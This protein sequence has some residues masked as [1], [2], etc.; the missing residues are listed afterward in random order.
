MDTKEVVEYFAK[1]CMKNCTIIIIVATSKMAEA[2]TEMRNQV[3]LIA[4]NVLDRSVV[5]YGICTG[6]VSNM[7]TYSVICVL[8]L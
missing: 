1:F 8:T 4:K 3:Q 5:V 6:K 2:L 7:C